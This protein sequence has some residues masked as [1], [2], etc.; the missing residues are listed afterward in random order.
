MRIATTLVLLALAAP[1]TGQSLDPALRSRVDNIFS[2][3]GPTT[4]GCA[5]GV[6]RNGAITYATGYGMANLE[7]NVPITPNTVFDIGSTSKQFTTASILLL[8][9][10]GKLSLDDDVR[11]WVPELPAYSSPVTIRHLVHHTSG[12][13][14]YLALMGLRGIHF[15]GVTTDTDAL[16]L[17][18]RQKELN[19][20]PGSEYLY[21]NSGYF[22]LGEIVKRVSG[23]PL[24]TFAQERIFAPLGMAV[25]HYHDDHTMVVP[26]RATGYAPRRDSGFAVSMSFFEQ[27]GDGAVYTTVEELLKWD[28][29]FYD[30]RVGGRSLLDALHV[31]GVLNNGDTLTYAGGLTV[32]ELRGLHR[33]SHGGSWAGYRAE[34]MRFPDQR[35]SVAV[36]CN[37]AN[38]NPTQLATRVAEILLESHMQPV[39]TKAAAPITAPRPT[40]AEVTPPAN[41]RR[42]EYTGEFYSPELDI[43]YRIRVQDA[44]L[45][46][47]YPG[48]AAE[49]LTWREPD[50]FS[51]GGNYLRLAF[52]RE[53]GQVR[54]FTLG[55]GRARNIRFEKR[56]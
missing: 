8:V 50:N 49:E 33:V 55:A 17:I 53:G 24:R 21:S 54:S 11:K 5:L 28:N 31:R 41:L 22:L 19:F 20:P 47:E 32:D 14:D 6:Y 52:Q 10:E 27:T 15:D 35:T 29:N 26:N 25:T 40:S 2:Q 18:V 51:A 46:L 9:N 30:P 7:W 12:L 13:R 4:P 34:L 48:N 1:L 23:K 45:L 44:K 39:D 16:D 43:T 38:T 42:E 3:F 56:P 37:Q 36:L